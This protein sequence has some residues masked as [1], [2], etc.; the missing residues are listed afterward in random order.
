MDEDWEP[1]IPQTIVPGYIFDATDT[2]REISILYL[3]RGIQGSWLCIYTVIVYA[4]KNW[5]IETLLW[6]FDRHQATL[7]KM[8]GIKSSFSQMISYTFIKCQ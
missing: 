3:I 8:E 6:S 7:P 2:W 4:T 1:S 5:K